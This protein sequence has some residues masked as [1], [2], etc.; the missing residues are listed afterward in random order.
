MSCCML[1]FSCTVSWGDNFK[2]LRASLPLGFQPH[3]LGI[4]GWIIPSGGP[5]LAIVER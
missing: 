4:W 1:I 5:V 2:S 3:Y